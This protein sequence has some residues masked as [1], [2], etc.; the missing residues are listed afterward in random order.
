MYQCNRRVVAV[1]LAAGIGLTGVSVAAPAA[2]AAKLNIGVAPS[3]NGYVMA[4]E[5]TQIAVSGTKNAKVYLKRDGKWR[6]LGTSRSNR[7]VPYTFTESGLQ[8]V[9]VKPRKGKAKIFKVPVYGKRESSSTQYSRPEAFAGQIFT[10]SKWGLGSELSLPADFG[11][12]LLDVGGKYTSIE[13]LSTGAPPWQGSSGPDDEIA[14][15]GI[16][17]SG[18][19]VVTWTRL[20]LNSNIGYNA[21]CLDSDAPA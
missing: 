19:T 17:I 8:Q 16:P 3:P 5:P 12:V 18:D 9:R 10:G 4:G 13:V 6:L 20:G 11:C 2:T 14:Q 21:I 1:V 7:A 15:M